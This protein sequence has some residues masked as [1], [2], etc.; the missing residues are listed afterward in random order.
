[1]EMEL[2]AMT[3]RLS[4]MGI[5]CLASILW[6]FIVA[7]AYAKGG[8]LGGGFT[9]T[10]FFLIALFATADSRSGLETKK[11][12][13]TNK[14]QTKFLDM[15]GVYPLDRSQGHIYIFSHDV[16]DH[17]DDSQKFIPAEELKTITRKELQTNRSNSKGE[18]V[19]PYWEEVT[20]TVMKSSGEPPKTYTIMD[21][22]GLFDT[23]WE[24]SKEQYEYYANESANKWDPDTLLY[25]NNDGVWVNGKTH[26]PP[27]DDD[28]YLPKVKID[29]MNAPVEFGGEWG[30][31]QWV[32]H[33]AS[34]IYCFGLGMLPLLG[35]GAALK[36]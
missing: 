28:Y 13:I 32:Y 25:K 1:M 10:I 11:Q 9:C 27:T 20:R 4:P 16:T 30:L 21:G 22:G 6:L 23:V 33:P 14:S 15:T 3:D 8:F 26:Q 31:A 19:K 29:R 2:L 35:L 18:I 5:F 34:A 17:S 24:S 36:N 7:C 12:F